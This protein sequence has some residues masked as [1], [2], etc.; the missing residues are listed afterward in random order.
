MTVNVTLALLIGVLVGCGVSL[1]MA[2]GIIRAFLGVVLMSN[3]LN[4]LF[5]VAAGRPGRAPIVGVTSEE[6]MA[7]PL[8]QALMLT[9]IVIT[10]AMTGFVMALAH[11]SWQLASTDAIVDDD[12]D[13]RIGLKAVEN[14][15]S[16]SDFHGGIEAEPID[17]GDD[18]DPGACHHPSAEREAIR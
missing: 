8:P 4:L 6:E 13:T 16:D 7:D 17:P 1:L 11:R 18:P 9:A 2:R 14:D 15:L 10:L 5:I 12:E 3:G